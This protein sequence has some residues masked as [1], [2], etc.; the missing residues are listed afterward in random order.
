MLFVETVHT[1]I[2]AQHCV[3][4]MHEL[5]QPD[6]RLE[7]H[8]VLWCA[9]ST[10]QKFRNLR[11]PWAARQDLAATP[12]NSRERFQARRDLPALAKRMRE[13]RLAR[14]TA[15]PTADV[16]PSRFGSPPALPKRTDV[17]RSPA[18]RRASVCIGVMHHG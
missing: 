11:A 15:L 18:P 12:S 8:A 16:E 4:A 1:H 6:T 3:P 9:A 17:V 13:V 10:P 5:C 2:N 7:P 14:R